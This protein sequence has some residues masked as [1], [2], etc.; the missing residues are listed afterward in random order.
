M[1]AT[2]Q[3]EPWKYRTY[4]LATIK[5][6]D[7]EVIFNQCFENTPKTR[8]TEGKQAEVAML[9]NSN[10]KE[11]VEGNTNISIFL[12]ISYSP[13]KDCAGELISFYERHKRDITSFIVQFSQCYYNLSDLP[14]LDL[15]K[16]GVTL[17]AMSKDLWR[18]I[19]INFETIFPLEL[20]H[21]KLKESVEERDT[22]SESRLK[23]K[24]NEKKSDDS[25]IDLDKL[26][27]S[28]DNDYDDD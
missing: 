15:V 22:D 28:D 3:G 19:G 10:W 12:T 8:R 23:N 6:R 7:G 5:N 20:E 14:I 24:L 9:D 1:T 18:E 11:I 16:A 27:L 21:L 25:D 4:L 26:T 2:K 17:L 13:C